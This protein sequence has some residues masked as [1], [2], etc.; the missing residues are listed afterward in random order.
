MYGKIHGP[1]HQTSQAMKKEADPIMEI[2]KRIDLG[3][4]VNTDESKSIHVDQDRISKNEIMSYKPPLANGKC[5]LDMP[6]HR[7]L[8][9]LVLLTHTLRRWMTPTNTEHQQWKES[10]KKRARRVDETNGACSN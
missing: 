9:G 2:L 1:K 7:S 4:S 5:K 6:R 10:E 8:L 3:Q